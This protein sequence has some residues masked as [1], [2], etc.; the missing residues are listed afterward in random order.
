MPINLHLNETLNRIRSRNSDQNLVALAKRIAAAYGDDKVR[1]LSSREV[2]RAV[3]LH[4]VDAINNVIAN[5]PQMSAGQRLDFC[6]AFV[7]E[8]MSGLDLAT[9]AILG[10]AY[11]A[12]SER[13]HDGEPGQQ[14]RLDKITARID[15]LSADFA[16][17]GGMVVSQNEWPLVDTNNVA[18]V[19]EGFTNMLNARMA[20]IDATKDSEKVTEMRANLRL[21]QNAI[22]NYDE[23]WGLKNLRHED[24]EKLAERWDELYGAL[25]R[26]ELSEDT[27]KKLSKY[28][29]LDSRNRVIPQFVSGKRGDTEKYEEYE[30]GFRIAKDG[31]LA[32]VVELARH[33]I[34]KKH[35]AEVDKDIDEEELEFELNEQ[36]LTKL[37]EID[38]ADKVIQVATENPEQ[39]TDPKYREEFINNLAQDGGEVSDVGYDAAIEAQTNATAGWAARVK[40]K[41]GSRSGKFGGF[42]GRVFQPIKHID[43]M[44]DVRMSRRTVDKREK[45]IEFFTRILKGFAS[46]FIASALI[47]TIATAAAAAA[48]VSVAMSLAAIGIVT[49]IGMGVIQITRWRRAQEAA[50]LPTDINEFLKDKR[51]VASLGA[52]LVAVVAMCFGVAGVATAAKWLGYGALAI[53]GVNNAAAVYRDAHDAKMS[54]AESIA[55]AILNAGAVIGGGFAGRAVAH[56]GI[57]AF[58]KH[59]PRNTVFQNETTRSEVQ[60]NT[61]TRDTTE[62]RIEY[63][64]DALDNAERI[65]RM[66]YHDNPDILQQRVD[67]INAYNAE[68]GTNIDPYRAIMI[69]GDAGGQ[70]FDN[71]RLHVN[72]SRIDSNIN[73]VYSH[74]HHRVLTDA[75]GQANGISHD[76]LNAARQLFNGP[77]TEAKMDAIAKLDNLVSESNTVGSV[78]GRPVQTDNYFK[79]ND[80]AGWTS[81]TDGNP[82]KVENI[83]PS[84][85]TVKTT[86]TVDYT[87]Y[88]PASGDG[89]AAFGNYSPRERKTVLRDRL[90]SFADRVRGALRRDNKPMDD[91]IVQHDTP[92]ED[93]PVF[94]PVIKEQEEQV[95][96]IPPFVPPVIEP[97]IEKE[98]EQLPPMREERVL[99]EVS[100]D[101]VFP[102]P[103]FNNDNGR[104]AE[105]R[106][107]TEPQPEQVG[108]WQ[109]KDMPTALPDPEKRKYEP[110]SDFAF[111]L[112]EEQA[113]RWNNLHKQLATVR[114]EMRNS[115]TRA[116][117]MLK[118]RK[119]ANRLANEINSFQNEL[120]NPS[121][122]E[123]EQALAEID[124]RKKL[125]SLLN[126]YENHM[127]R[128]PKGSDTQE[129]RYLKWKTE[130]QKLL[131]KIADLGGENSLDDS[132]L[133]FATPKLGRFEQKQAEVAQREMERQEQKRDV[134]VMPMREQ[135]REKQ[136]LETE[137]QKVD[138]LPEPFTFEHEKPEFESRYKREKRFDISNHTVSHVDVKS[139]LKQ[140]NARQVSEHDQKPAEKRI[141]APKPIEP[142]V[143]ENNLGTVLKTAVYKSK[144]D[145]DGVHDVPESLV[146]LAHSSDI[147][148]TPITEI[149]GVPVKLIDITGQNNPFTQNENRAMV[150]VDVDGLRIPF[151]LANGNEHGVTG[152]TGVWRPV[153]TLD[154]KG[155]WYINPSDYAD[156]EELDDIIDALNTRIGDIR[157]YKDLVAS[158]ARRDAGYRGFVGGVDA[159][160]HVDPNKILDIVSASAKTKDNFMV[161]SSYGNGGSWSAKSGILSRFL[162]EVESPDYRPPRGVIVKGVERLGERMRRRFGWRDRG[163]K[164]E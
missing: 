26:A 143:E 31:R 18:D 145:V 13:A 67:A 132:N 160:E 140:A 79:P 57:E 21:M 103:L 33:D 44:A 97:V 133:R 115:F 108:P 110:L 96:E 34:A 144:N 148:S 130:S 149:R 68:H 124:R 29:F 69:N 120:G 105:L 8:D 114:A 59:S 53:G 54:A 84:Q 91:E 15:E 14:E 62:T 86:T 49:A 43:K 147:I 35:V 2:R 127:R 58:N 162:R 107:K 23:A 131:D 70:T 10:D 153:L 138:V 22:E 109:F 16:N 89:M 119:Q 101:R 122:F 111:A 42:F 55:W 152:N 93:T 82:A 5:V 121:T 129:W 128:E 6:D 155:R 125:Q 28:K 85:E 37:F 151:Y 106:E 40:N 104:L 126:Q 48:G 39:F 137:K 52:S 150:I 80:P 9:P 123:I 47:T 81:Y 154:S 87:D 65:S 157:N 60:E 17:S 77:I 142:L 74:G 90:G 146:K 102:K 163:K 11:R 38:S 139:I 12:I 158:S 32:S 4:D 41:L 141:E 71:M 64:Q 61:T 50:G 45:R 20:E 98:P 116:D 95:D 94:T 136:T 113:E 164:Y 117:K 99:P 88:T 19:Y 92:K 156:S 1:L 112:T 51:L 83:Y 56:A 159:V 63:T 25:N 46:G 73:D 24:A 66:W 118:L 72:N 76:E 78:H 7:G 36:V 135:P 134:F 30:P 161:W 3:V 75:W 100:A 27:K